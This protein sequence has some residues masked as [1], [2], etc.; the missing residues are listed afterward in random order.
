[1]SG[2]GKIGSDYLVTEYLQAYWFWSWQPTCAPIHYSV[3]PCG[4]RDSHF[5]HSLIASNHCPCCGVGLASA[6]TLRS[7]AILRMKRR[8][9]GSM[10]GNLRP[11]LSAC[12]RSRWIC[13]TSANHSSGV[14]PT[15][16]PYP[17]PAIMMLTTVTISS[18][19]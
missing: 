14:G 18:A 19:S 10:L 13:T 6:E 15:Q 11:S 16:R 17:Q 2:H 4:D 8:S 12:S 9:S 1:P 7:F 3:P 5:N